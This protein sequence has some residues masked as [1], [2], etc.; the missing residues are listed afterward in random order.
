LA[1]QIKGTSHLPIDD[2]T[3]AAEQ[4]AR[5]VP[6]GRVVTAFTFILASGGL[7]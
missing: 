7:R 3:I 1:L 4:L 2:G 5:L 6:K